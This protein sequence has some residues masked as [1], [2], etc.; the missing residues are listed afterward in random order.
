MAIS[1]DVKDIFEQ[2]EQESAWSNT[3]DEKLCNYYQ[4]SQRLVHL[5]LAVPPELRAFETIVNWP[6]LYVDAIEQ[7]QDVKMILRPGET[8]A[9]QWLQDLYRVNNLASELTLFRQDMYVY[10]RGFLC[11][12][13]NEAEPDFPL[14]TVESPRE[15]TVDVDARAR[16][17][18]NALR[19]YNVKDGQPQ[20]ATLYQ[21]DRTVWFERDA[22]G[23]SELD[24]DDHKLGRVPIVMGL[25][26]RRTG[27]W[28][29]VSQMADVIGLTDAAA[30][31]LTN[32]QVAQETHAVPARWA[33]GMSNG[34]FTDS[35]G[36]MLP[37]WETYFGAVWA[38]ENGQAK[39]GQFSASDLKNF[40]ETVE[41]YAKQ[42][43]A[44][45]GL[46]ADY[47]G[48]NTTNP[49]GEGAIR[50]LE[51]RLVKTTE[52]K[53][54]QEGTILGWALGIA[55]RIKTGEW[56]QGSR[57][58]VLY[59]DPGTPTFAQK[60]DALQK[61][62]GGKSIISREGAWDELGWSEARKDQE[63]GYMQSELSAEWAAMEPA[64][65]GD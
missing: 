14:I 18:K 37:T 63:R 46:P 26:R 21:Q 58:D 28:S 13:S 59:H 24:R 64:V 48:I 55:E 60:S 34:D 41:L 15:M 54:T 10:G 17:I 43:A 62:A 32:L 2:L 45:T 31:S 33:A 61:L 44:L 5:G 42:V 40:H 39:F 25:N 9:D 65:G 22:S 53:N 12:G 35:D 49:P 8:K 30:R 57:V 27:D 1:D 19:L 7:R 52:R 23:W 16:Q 11:V 50:A 51:A 38:T 6:R 3:D 20:N 36:K 4:G 29:G 56:P 47:Y